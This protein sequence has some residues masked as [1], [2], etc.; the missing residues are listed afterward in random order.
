ML[1]PICFNSQFTFNFIL[2]N[3]GKREGAV[4][5]ARDTLSA[6]GYNYKTTVDAV[7]FGVKQSYYVLLGSHSHRQSER[8]DGKKPRVASEA[9]ERFL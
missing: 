1:L 7:I 6:T 3:F 8:G 5:A 4:Q 9:G 2:Y